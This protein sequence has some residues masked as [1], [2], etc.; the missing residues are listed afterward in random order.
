MKGK[1]GWPGIAS[2]PCDEKEYQAALGSSRK[3]EF[4][5]NTEGCLSP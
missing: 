5:N 4:P 2:L 1:A 3:T